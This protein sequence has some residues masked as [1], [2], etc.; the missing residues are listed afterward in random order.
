MLSPSVRHVF[1]LTIL[2]VVNRL[3]TPHVCTYTTKTHAIYALTFKS[4]LNWTKKIFV[5]RQLITHLI[6]SQRV[7]QKK[8]GSYSE[9]VNG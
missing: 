5:S 3:Y 7:R 4:V 9:R 8:G 6:V 1:F 2:V